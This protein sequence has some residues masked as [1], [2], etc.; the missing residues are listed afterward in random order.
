MTPF[1][2]FVP[3]NPIY[4][5]TQAQREG[6]INEKTSLLT[7]RQQLQTRIQEF[8]DRFAQTP[9]VERDYSALLRDLQSEQLKY[10]DVRQKQMEAQL[11]SNLETESKGERFQLIEPPLEPQRPSS[12][13]RVL[14]LTLGIVLSLISA[15]GLMLVL[16]STDTRIQGRGDILSLLQIPPLAIVPWVDSVKVLAARRRRLR[17]AVAGA[18]GLLVVAMVLV[19]M[20]I[21]PLDMLWYA[22]LRRFG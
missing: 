21:L 22:V 1:A 14:I 17:Y 16:E 4:I 2:R 10:A 7:K 19:H 5:Q 3:D 18:F 11:A 13:N 8:E 12:P 20:L 15:F 9:G 6:L